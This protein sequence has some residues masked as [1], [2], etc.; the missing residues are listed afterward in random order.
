MNLIQGSTQIKHVGLNWFKRWS[1]LGLGSVHEKIDVWTGSQSHIYDKWQ[2]WICT[3]WPSFP[4][5]CALLLITSTPK[6]EAWPRKIHSCFTFGLFLA[7]H[8]LSWDILNLNLMFAFCH[9]CHSKSVN[10]QSYWFT[11][12]V[13][14]I[15]SGVSGFCACTVIEVSIYN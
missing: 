10:Y 11:Y 7:V 3:L 15:S 12:I 8:L 2:T 1:D 14:E 4:L 13:S 9:K 5:T 6:V